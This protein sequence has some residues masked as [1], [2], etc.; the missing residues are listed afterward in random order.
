MQYNAKKGSVSGF[1]KNWLGGFRGSTDDSLT[2]LQAFAADV[3]LAV[4]VSLGQLS[5]DIVKR[6][7]GASHIFKPYTKLV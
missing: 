5:G 2:S 1:I 4:V 3:C 7:D 6:K